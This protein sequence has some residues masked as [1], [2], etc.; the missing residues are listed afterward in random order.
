M[1]DYNGVKGK[2]KKKINRK[3]KEK[4]LLTFQFAVPSFFDFCRHL[5][6][7][8]PLP[9]GLYISYYHSLEIPTTYLFE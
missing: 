2:R 8:A 1:G 5:L 6:Y 4:D 9:L 7:Y 3:E